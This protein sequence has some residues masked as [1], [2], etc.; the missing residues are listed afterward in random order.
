MLAFDDAFMHGQNDARRLGE[1]NDLWL[2]DVSIGHGL[3][4]GLTVLPLVDEVKVEL[5]Y[6]L[7]EDAAIKQLL[8]MFVEGIAVC[9]RE[10]L[11]VFQYGDVV[12][13]SENIFSF[14]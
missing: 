13:L 4:R 10:P 14:P 6:V 3:L 8:P 5:C 9:L 7:A 12:A 1:D 11:I 2:P